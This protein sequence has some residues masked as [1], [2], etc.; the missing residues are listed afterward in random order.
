MFCQF[1]TAIGASFY[2]FRLSLNKP[3][4]KKVIPFT[5]HCI[6]SNYRICKI[7][8]QFTA[9]IWRCFQHFCHTPEGPEALPF[10]VV[11]V[12]F[13]NVSLVIRRGGSKCW[14]SSW[15]ILFSPREFDIHETFI[16]QFPC[17]FLFFFIIPRLTPSGL[18]KRPQMA[19]IDYA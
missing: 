15:Q 5:R 17:F 10:F 1:H 18:Q 14:I 7:C 16:I 6:F 8:N 3:K 13:T 2:G 12:D 4:I 9:Y 19:I 11:Q